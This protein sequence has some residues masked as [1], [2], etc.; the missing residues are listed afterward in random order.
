MG[1]GKMVFPGP[2]NQGGK[3]LLTSCLR[4]VGIDVDHFLKV[5]A[6]IV[7]R[8]P[9]MDR[10]RTAQELDECDIVGT[11]PVYQ[12]ILERGEDLAP[13]ADAGSALPRTPLTVLPESPDAQHELVR[14]FLIS[15]TAKDCSVMIAM[16]PDGSP[17]DQVKPDARNL[18]ISTTGERVVE[19]G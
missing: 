18:E 6:N 19:K 7:L 3:E 9:L 2:K 8:E 17:K 15:C 5:L 4:D 13:L 1:G 16:R 12:Q 14:R 11:W 10:L